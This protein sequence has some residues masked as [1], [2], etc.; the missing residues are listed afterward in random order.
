M[1]L[2]IDID[3]TICTQEE[4]G[5]YE[6]ARPIMD[7]IKKINELYDNGHEITYWSA[8]GSGSGIDWTKITK[9]Q[10]SK[11]GVNIII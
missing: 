7:N 5:N 1:I 6:N 9:N 3:D 11:W 8:R 10:F 4:D 2:Y